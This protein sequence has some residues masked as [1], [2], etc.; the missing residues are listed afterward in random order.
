MQPSNTAY[1]DA[2]RTLL[3]D[4]KELIIPVVN[5]VFDEKYTGREEIIFAT[6]EYFLA[7]DDGNETKR[8]T[9]SCFSIVSG[10]GDK[11]NYHL[12]CECAPDSSILVRIFEYDAQIALSSAVTGKG[13]LTVTFPHT[14]VLALRDNSA[15]PDIM[16]VH[17]ITP[18][19]S[20]NYDVRL[21]RVQKYGL[22]DIFGKKLLFFLPFHI[23]CHEV[24]FPKYESDP[25]Q[26]E[27]LVREY[28]YIREQLEK[29][30]KN[31]DIDGFTKNAVCAMVNHV[32]A[33]IAKNYDNVREGVEHTMRG[34]IVDYE[35]KTI[36][37][38]GRE[39]GR[40][41]GRKEGVK[42]GREEGVEECAMD[43]LRDR[44]E[45]SL[46]EKYTHLPLP[47]IK[48]LALALGVL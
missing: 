30:Q 33:L 28:A 9:D 23:F 5:D 24:D 19:G 40:E 36:L 12:E 32:L 16:S 2:F 4:C 14:A 42:K 22:D 44:V 8:I 45:L 20:A 1:D 37:N 41:E 13:T 3:N 25:E 21:V 48:E 11:K 39:E 46:V 34:K 26:R 38:K 17:V 15:L 7:Q 6:N 18:G 43:M 35:A 47:R 31:G 27:K 10:N 29:M